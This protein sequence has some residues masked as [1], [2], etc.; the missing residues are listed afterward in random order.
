MRR[1]ASA[2]LTLTTPPKLPEGATVWAAFSGGLDSTVL[3]HLLKTAALPVK[4]LHVNHQLQPAA[5]RW[6]EHCRSVSA[7]LGVPIYVMDVRID[8]NDPSGPEAAARSARYSAFRSVMKP[9]D[10]LATA[11]HQDDQAETVLL[12]LMRG[13]GVAGLAAMRPVTEFPPGLLWRPLLHRT[14]ADLRRHAERRQLPWVEDPHN[15]DPRYSRSF[16]RSEIF[17][18]LQQRWPQ[19][20]EQLARTA[21]HCADAVEL[22]DEIARRDFEAAVIPAKAGIQFSYLSVRRLLQLPRSRRNNLLRHWAVSGGYELPPFDALSR[23]ER[24]V[25]RARPDSAPLLV[26]GETELRRFRDTLYVMRRLPAA[27][28]GVLEWNGQADLPL[29]KACGVLKVLRPARSEL[30]LQVSFV[31][32]GERIKPVGSRYTR[33]LRNLFQEAAVPPWVRE[34][35]PLIRLEGELAA[36]ADRWES[37]ALRN[38]RR[39][40]G[41]R[42]EWRHELHGDTASR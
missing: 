37:A 23:I 26:W 18:R 41:L 19:A 35:M 36:V 25:L 1:E 9:G 12:R 11:H 6:V 5:G 42:Y 30:P 28:D 8:P 10:C 32:G 22:L 17:P 14:R 7:Q 27:P 33:T 20:V 21:E 39:R 40:Q 16:L 38:V 31:R 3:L 24:E 34:R 29:P 4:A 2:E 15:L 13:A